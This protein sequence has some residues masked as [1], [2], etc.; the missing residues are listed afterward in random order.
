MN[1]E[2]GQSKG[3]VG[4]NFV[5]TA[6]EGS[7]YLISQKRVGFWANQSQQKK[8]RMTSSGTKMVMR[9]VKQC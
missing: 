9:F 6:N 2:R 4:F 8:K 5:F 7:Q 1:A 3:S